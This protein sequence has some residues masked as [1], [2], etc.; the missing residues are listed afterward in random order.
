[1]ATYYSDS[2]G[3]LGTGVI[4]PTLPTP[5]NKFKLGRGA[6]ARRM[7]KSSISSGL[8]AAGDIVGLFTLRSA[9]R[10]FS[11]ALNTDG[12][13]TAGAVHL[14]LYVYG[15][16]A[17]PVG[18][19]ASAASASMFVAAQ[20]LTAAASATLLLLTTPVKAYHRGSQIWE[21]VNVV[22]AATYAADP[23]LT[24]LVA[25]TCS[26]TITGTAPTIVVE[27]QF[28]SGS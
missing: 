7:T 19:L 12:V 18:A 8:L 6:G 4:D 15:G 27:A 26:T 20:A 17:S 22:N 25:L 14:G 24:Y 28:T 11:V 10:L 1:M 13:A 21:M 5:L 9:D 23:T 2:F 3:A 16:A